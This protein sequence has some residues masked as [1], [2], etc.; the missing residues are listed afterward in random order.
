MVEHDGHV[1]KLLDKLD[2][3]GIADNTIVMYSTDNG[4]EVMS[5]PDGG[6][7]PFRGEKDTNFEGGWRVPCAIRWPGMIK[8]APCP[9]RSSR[10]PTCCRRWPRRRRPDVVE[11]LKKGYKSGNKTFKVHIDGYNL[12]PVPEG[13]VKENPRKGFLYWSDDGDLMACASATGSARSWSSARTDWL[14]GGAVVS[15]RAP[16]LY[17]LRAIRSSAATRTAAS[18]TTSGWRTAPSCSCR[19]GDRRGVPQDV[20]GIPA[21][22]A[23]ASFSIDQALEKARQQQTAM[24][25]RGA[26]GAK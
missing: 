2:E 3:L 9:T 8:P 25:T 1:G 18:S 20:Q 12:L 5:W 4:A 22:T 17:N 11:K 6:T 24:A 13:E 16:K 23:A 21:A 19:P 15:L 26:V 7:T 10:T 14:S